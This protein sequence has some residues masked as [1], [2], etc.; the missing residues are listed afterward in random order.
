MATNQNHNNYN[1]ERQ[2][3]CKFFTDD[4]DFL[5]LIQ[6]EKP[7]GKHSYSYLEK[8]M[9]FSDIPQ[10]G[11]V[12]LLSPNYSTRAKLY[13]IETVYRHLSETVGRDIKIEYRI[14]M[15]LL[16]VATRIV[17][18][19]KHKAVVPP[20]RILPNPREAEI[21]RRYYYDCE[22]EIDADDMEGLLECIEVEDKLILSL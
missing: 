10:I 17:M 9:F 13:Q 14:L 4:K 1:P 21:D 8:D 5:E 16:Y 22:G 6:E 12:I 7:R 19:E 18:V 3:R 15:K 20:V 2:Y 11:E